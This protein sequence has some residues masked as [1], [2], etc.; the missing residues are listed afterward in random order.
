LS[1]WRPALV[2]AG[3]LGSRPTRDLPQ[4]EIYTVRQVVAVDR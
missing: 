4:A 1:V 2:R 3:L